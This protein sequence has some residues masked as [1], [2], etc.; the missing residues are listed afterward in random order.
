MSTPS[1]HVDWLRANVDQP[2]PAISKPRKPRVF[3]RMSVG[4]TTTLCGKA[5]PPHRLLT[6]SSATSQRV[7]C[8]QCETLAR[9]EIDLDW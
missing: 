6:G 1:Q 9:F 3:H 2:A 7:A 8:P 5:I 4:S